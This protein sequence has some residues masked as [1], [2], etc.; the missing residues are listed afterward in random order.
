LLRKER[1]EDTNL[2][3]AHI[4]EII[5]I[6]WFASHNPFIGIS[7]CRMPAA[8]KFSAASS[9]DKAEKLELLKELEMEK[10][11]ILNTLMDRSLYKPLCIED[12]LSNISIA[13][14][15]IELYVGA[16]S[17]LAQRISYFHHAI[18]ANK[19]DLKLS[20]AS[21]ENLLTKI[22]YVFDTRLNKWLGRVYENSENL[23]E[24]NHKLIEFESIIDNILLGNFSVNLPPNLLPKK[25]NKRLVPTP[26]GDEKDSREKKKVKGEMNENIIPEFEIKDD[27]ETKKKYLRREFGAEG[28]WIVILL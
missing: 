13:Q 11:E 3:V 17:A 26:G 19:S 10:S 12:L 8:S 6:K 18:R 20:M 22:Q 1:Q 15:I 27:E 5:S 9:F 21:D 23:I 24:V 16:E 25:N 2:E 4:T 14:G 7:L 28:C